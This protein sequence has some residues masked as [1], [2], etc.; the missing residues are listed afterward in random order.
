LCLSENYRIFSALLLIYLTLALIGK[1][2]DDR[3]NL[4]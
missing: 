3:R 1:N 2:I 4:F